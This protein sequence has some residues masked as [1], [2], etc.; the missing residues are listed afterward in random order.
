MPIQNSIS[1]AI[2]GSIINGGGSAADFSTKSLSFDGVDE[3]IST[4]EVYSELDGES[5]ATFSVWIKPTVLDTIRIVTHTP[6]NTT[7]SNSQFLMFLRNNGSV[8]FSVSSA[9][10]YARSNAGVITAGAWNH[11]FIC[12]DFAT[13]GN[14]QMFVNGSSEL[15][16]Q[17][18]NSLS[19]FP[20]STGELYIGEEANG[21]QSL[22]LGKIDEFAIWS[23]QDLSSNVATI[24]NNGKPS[25]LTGTKPTSWYRAGENSTFAYPQILMPED[26]NKNKVSKYSLNFDGSF[27][28]ITMGNVLN[29]QDDGAE[30]YSISCW[31]K[32]TD[33]GLQLLVSKQLNS[34]P[35]NG[36]N[37]YLDANRIKFSFGTVSGSA[38]INGQSSSLISSITDG[39]W[40]H[41][42]LTYDG[43]QDITGFNL[44]YDNSPTAITAISNNTPS[45]LQSNADFMI[46]ARGIAAGSYGLS[47]DGNIDEVAFWTTELSST[48]VSS[49]YNN[50]VPTDIAS[51]YPTR[52]EGYWKLGEEA[53]F[54]NTWLVPNSA[55]SNFSKYSFNFDGMDDYVTVSNNSNIDF[56]GA[57]SYSVWFKTTD[58]TSTMALTSNATKFLVQLYSP[59]TRIRCQVFDGSGSVKNVDIN[60]S[61]YND[62]N[63]HHIAFTTD[64]LTTTNGV[65]VYYDGVL[66]SQG[67]LSNSGIRSVSTDWQLG[68]HTSTWLY[69]GLMDEVSLFSSELSAAAVTDIYNGGK[70][71]D[72]SG[73]SPVSWWRMGE[74]ATY[75][76]TSNQFT[77]PDQAGTNN[78]TS[79][80]TM[81]L[82]TLVGDT[83]QYSNAGKSV[84][85]D[86]FDRH[87]DA[88]KS[89]N[90]TVS[91]NMEEADI[92]EDTP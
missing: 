78:G 15:S 31:F 23:G 26:T 33:T 57:F 73:L 29:L 17:N 67:T 12:I 54:T 11:I 35:Y 83:P 79:S 69:N 36:Y 46:G 19:T 56:T 27:D 28:L 3:Y 25:D 60:A 8:D 41:V 74:K 91:F 81:L 51:L 9:S 42:V 71:K 44:Y 43:T 49:I 90:N 66:T 5:K 76:G 87:G 84:G 30:P 75:D 34:S 14:V 1:N 61:G 32:T 38:N 7:A 18:M 92:V 37:L 77:I 59:T 39:N 48:T 47:F 40:H 6:K 53:K 70:P 13:E 85:L 82:E 10:L 80:N 68:K 65:K 72:L 62:G 89:K 58:T 64:A 4:S 55:L 86:I 45:N 88:P 50:G 52:L 22:L 24:Y 20:V 16:V 21:Y 2:K 63:W